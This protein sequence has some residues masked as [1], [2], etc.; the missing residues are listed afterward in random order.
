M[1]R[2]Q[3]LSDDYWD[4]ETINHLRRKR[5]VGGYRA[6]VNTA[7]K[8]HIN[9]ARIGAWINAIKRVEEAMKMRGWC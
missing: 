6:A 7:A 3:G 4:I 8:Y 9:S 5:L 1:E 2:S